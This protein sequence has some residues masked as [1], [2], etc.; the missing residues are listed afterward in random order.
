[1][2][3]DEK[4]FY[5]SIWAGPASG[6]N[7]CIYHNTGFSFKNFAKWM[8]FF[9]YR[10]ALYQVANPKH[11]VDFRTGS[12]DYVP[13]IEQKIKKLKDDIQGKKATITK[14]ENRMKKGKAEWNELF[15]IEQDRF[16]IQAGDKV[17][18]LK[19]ELQI[20]EDAFKKLIDN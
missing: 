15:P 19:T 14:I 2:H 17:A 4:R 7:P 3:V 13:P 18:R 5:V 8:W 12:F 16:Y 11:I 6:G 10:A 1:M 20:L 9:K